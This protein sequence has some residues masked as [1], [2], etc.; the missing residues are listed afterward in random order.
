MPR[1]WES[2]GVFGVNERLTACSA[3][4][5]SEWLVAWQG[6][7]SPMRAS[8][9]SRACSA[10]A[11]LQT[12]TFENIW[13]LPD[14]GRRSER[15][16]WP[17]RKRPPYNG[18]WQATVMH[19]FWNPP[20]LRMVAAPPWRLS[21]PFTRRWSWL[22][23]GTCATRSMRQNNKITWPVNAGDPLPFPLPPPHISLAPDPPGVRRTSR[24][25]KFVSAST[26]ALVCRSC[27]RV[28]TRARVLKVESPRSAD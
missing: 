24:R 23:P 11:I 21:T 4:T 19:A 6:P 26:H 22:R 9:D 28:R 5:P 1:D 7:A 2:G 18:R 27:T 3:S 20:S 15:P 25:R 17:S 14:A 12:A 8:I 10:A 13:S 16:V